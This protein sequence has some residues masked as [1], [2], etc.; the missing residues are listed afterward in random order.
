LTVVTGFCGFPK[1]AKQ[2]TEE[3]HEARYDY[4]STIY[5]FTI[6]FPPWL[7]PYVQPISVVPNMRAEARIKHMF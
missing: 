2:I 1:Y 4:L 7:A 5:P 6:I 3:Y